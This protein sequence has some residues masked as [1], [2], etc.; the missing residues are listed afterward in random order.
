MACCCQ[1]CVVPVFISKVFWANWRIPEPN[2]HD[3]QWL[4]SYPVQKKRL[5]RRAQVVDSVSELLREVSWDILGSDSS[6]WAVQEALSDI[7]ESSSCSDWFSLS[8]VV[9][10]IVAFW[11]LSLVSGVVETDQFSSPAIITSSQ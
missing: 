3:N 7:W 5:S 4:S 2:A 8:W 1:V 9:S 11:R 6:V 10:S